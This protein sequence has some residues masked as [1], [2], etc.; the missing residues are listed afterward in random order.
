MET[1]VAVVAEVGDAVE[2]AEGTVVEAHEAVDAGE[3]HAVVEVEVG[4]GL[5]L[6][7]LAHPLEGDERGVGLEVEVD[8]EDPADVVDALDAGGVEGEE[9]DAVG[10][11]RA[12][13]L[14]LL[15]VLDGVVEALEEGGDGEGL[16]ALLGGEGGGE[17]EEEEEEERH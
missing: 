14:V 5:E 11:V 15:L 6:G 8:V 4:V 17:E 16:F 3:V 7:L 2:Y 9:A 10:L 12:L 1:D 13:D